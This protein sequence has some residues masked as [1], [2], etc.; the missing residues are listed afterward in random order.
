MAVLLLPLLQL[1]KKPD[2]CAFFVF[3][4]RSGYREAPVFQVP[5]GGWKTTEGVCLKSLSQR[6]HRTDLLYLPPGRHKH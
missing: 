1:H 6:K 5:W 3:M 2:H 4:S